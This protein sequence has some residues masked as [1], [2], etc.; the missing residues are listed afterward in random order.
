MCNFRV[1]TLRLWLPQ[2]FTTIDEYNQAHNYSS[3][4][5]LCEMLEFSSDVNV[6][7]AEEFSIKECK[8]VSLSFN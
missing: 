7:T 4:A 6:T 3:D 5:S 1:N 2:L 8:V